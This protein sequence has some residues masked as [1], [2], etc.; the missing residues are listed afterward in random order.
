MR[1]M[2]YIDKSTD[3]MYFE[4]QLSESREQVEAK[5]KQTTTFT[6][7][8]YLGNASEHDKNPKR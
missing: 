2:E 5:I 4:G 7:I 6:D 3:L 8:E 1:L